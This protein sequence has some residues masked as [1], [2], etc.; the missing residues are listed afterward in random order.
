MNYLLCHCCLSPAEILKML[1]NEAAAGNLL[2]LFAATGGACA[3]DDS[4]DFIFA[5]DQQLFAVDLDF[6]TTVLAK[7]DAVAGF[8][9]Q[10]LAR[11]VFFVFPLTGRYN[12]AFLG[13][14]L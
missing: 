12:F 4:E 6:G 11:S 2:A 3:L 14:F 9:V 8:N 10:R 1:I 7:E 13:F 5:H